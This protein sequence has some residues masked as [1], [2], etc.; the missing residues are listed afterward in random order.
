MQSSAT[1]GRKPGPFNIAR[2]KLALF[3]SDRLRPG[4]WIVAASALLSIL[5]AVRLSPF[6]LWIR[7]PLSLITASFVVLVLFYVFGKLMQRYQSGKSLMPELV[8]SI[9][10][11]GLLMLDG[12]GLTFLFWISVTLLLLLF[13]FVGRRMPFYLLFFGLTLFALVFLSFRLVD[14]QKAAALA[15][16]Q[17]VWK[18]A[19]R[20]GTVYTVKKDQG[21]VEVLDQGAPVL[22]LEVPEGLHYH[23]AKKLEDR[24][25]PG[26]PLLAV[27]R[28]S[29]DRVPL[30]VLYQVPP[31]LNRET[32]RN[33][34]ELILGNIRDDQIQDLQK[35]KEQSLFPPDFNMEMSGSFWTYYDGFQAARLRAGFF[36]LAPPEGRSLLRGG[37]IL[38]ILEPVEE[39]FP[40]HPRTLDLLRS[41]QWAGAQ[42]ESRP[43]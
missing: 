8:F 22:S 34:T 28:E 43:Q 5:Y 25:G 27:G 9:V 20:S 14:V 18:S 21:A 7:L 17:Y 38:W 6:A 24:E 15:G 42:P 4:I 11:L 10:I 3:Q 19:A 41:F 40:F 35:E 31:G 29:L 16:Y 23:D 32:L 2:E 1:T 33:R 12:A 26:I 30:I 13:Y 39:G 36:V 37:L